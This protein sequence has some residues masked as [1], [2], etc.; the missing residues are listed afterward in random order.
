MRNKLAARCNVAGGIKQGEESGGTVS[1]SDVAFGETL[2][3]R[4]FCLFNV[5]ANF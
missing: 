3:R 4:R 1:A 2:C 5:C